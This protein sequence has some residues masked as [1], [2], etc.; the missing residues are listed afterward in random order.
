MKKQK[1]ILNNN[2]KIK[3]IIKNITPIIIAFLIV[4]SIKLFFFQS[5]VNFD[6]SMHRT[7]FKGDYIYINKVSEIKRNEIVLFELSLVK[8]KYFKRIVGLPGDVVFIQN[9]NVFINRKIEK[10][11]NKIV[12]KYSIIAFDARIKDFII[13]KFNLQETNLP[14]LEVLLTDNQYNQVLQDSII[15]NIEPIILSK[16]YNNPKIFPY[17]YQ[18]RWNQDNLGPII[19]PRKGV[20]IKLD[21]KSYALYKHVIQNYENNKILVEKNIFYIN[22]KATKTYTFKNDYYFVLNDNRSNYDD[23]R[24]FGIIPANNIKGKAMFVWFSF[25]EGKVLWNRIF[26]KI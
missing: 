16:K 14:Y 24:K 3:W 25:Y 17:S 7:I 15:K 13:K 2:S 19:L 12:K 11:C 1:S 8:K 20:T 9:K 10:S 18:F 26:N 4:V 23:S 21:K 5:Y 6:N 22:N